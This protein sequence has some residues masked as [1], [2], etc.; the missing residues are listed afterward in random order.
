MDV[1]FFLFSTQCFYYRRTNYTQTLPG[2]FSVQKVD[3]TQKPVIMS[4]NTAGLKQSSR[5][6]Q[7]LKIYLQCFTV[8]IAIARQVAHT[9]QV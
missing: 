2:A 6:V 8:F 1:F 4:Y 7:Y 3:V 9:R 5:F